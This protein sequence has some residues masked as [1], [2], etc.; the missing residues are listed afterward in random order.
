MLKLYAE[1]CSLLGCHP[2]TGKDGVSKTYG[3]A[4]IEGKFYDFISTEPIEDKE[5]VDAVFGFNY[6][7]KDGMLWQRLTLKEWTG[8]A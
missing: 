4:Y 2:Y 3:K 7:V 5:H 1:D 6:G 8:R